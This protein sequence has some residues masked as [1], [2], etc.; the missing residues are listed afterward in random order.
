MAIDL[1]GPRARVRD[2][3]MA[4]RVSLR[5]DPTVQNADDI[6]D[7]TGLSLTIPTS[8]ASVLATDVPAVIR[9][10]SLLERA[11]DD[12]VEKRWEISLGYDEAPDEIPIGCAITVDMT[13]DPELLGETL[14]V[15]RVFTG[16]LRVVRKV[17]C[18][19]RKSAVDRH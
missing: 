7:E 16:T 5:F 17:E 2:R 14:F 13:E 18:V 19:R 12:T 11:D 10:S 6:D 1:T 9:E 8:D 15:A 4:D 3:V